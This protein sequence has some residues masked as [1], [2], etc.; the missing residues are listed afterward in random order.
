MKVLTI[1]P[2]GSRVVR[3]TRADWCALDAAVEVAFG[4][5]E[6]TPEEYRG[7]GGSLV[8]TFHADANKSGWCRRCRAF[9]AIVTATGRCLSCH[10]DMRQQRRSALVDGTVY[11][12]FGGQWLAVVGDEETETILAVPALADGSIGNADAVVEVSSVE[13][14]DLPAVNLLFGTSFEPA[15]FP[16]R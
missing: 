4:D 1:N 11:F 12:Q 5:P 13:G 9:R 16:G 3:L 10:L 14:L 6:S 8:D 2:D 7:P 15:Q